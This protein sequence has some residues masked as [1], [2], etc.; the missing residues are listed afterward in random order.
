[1]DASSSGS[2]GP[3]CL[4]ER[5]S[6][7]RDMSEQWAFCERCHRWFYGDKAAS[8]A[9]QLRCPVCDAAPSMV[10]ERPIDPT[11]SAS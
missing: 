11:V 8:S 3:G 6:K 5:Y 9:N 7:E 1:V 4:L 2:P 10:R